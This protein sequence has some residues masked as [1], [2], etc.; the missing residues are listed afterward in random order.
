MRAQAIRAGE[1]VSMQTELLSPDVLR[2]ASYNPRK[3]DADRL[4]L[5]RLSLQK[6]GWLLPAYATVDG[7]I[8]S[9]HQRVFVARDLGYNHVPVVRLPAM[10]DNQRKALNI[11]F[12]RSTND[13]ALND[14]PLEY[15]ETWRIYRLRPECESCCHQAVCI[16][17]VSACSTCTA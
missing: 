6:L 17:F 4:A 16:Q 11:L 10:P 2:F 14:T 12:N 1:S 3:V 13:F 9:G 15:H 5:V 8:L 7:E